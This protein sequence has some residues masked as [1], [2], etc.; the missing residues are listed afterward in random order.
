MERVLVH[1]L[2]VPHVNTARTTSL[3]KSMSHQELQQRGEFLVDLLP[4]QV[5]S[6]APIITVL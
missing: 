2:M 4:E 5:C 3:D 1:L 6:A